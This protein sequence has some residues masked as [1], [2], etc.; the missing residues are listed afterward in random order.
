METPC[1]KVCV[2]DPQTR[3]CHGCARSLDEIAAWGSLA[4]AERARIMAALPG[5]RVAAGLDIVPPSSA[6]KIGTA[7][8]GS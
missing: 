1:I 8:S 3:L 5:R 2:I 7:P 6:A 4:A